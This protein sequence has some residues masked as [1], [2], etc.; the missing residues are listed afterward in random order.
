MMDRICVYCGSN[1]GRSA[2][3]EAAARQL[4]ATLAQQGIGLVYG[5]ASVGIMGILADEML[6]QGGEVVGV[7]PRLLVDK[8][9]AHPGLTELKIVQ[10]MHQRKAQMAELADGFIG[11]AGRPRNSGG[12]V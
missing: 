10:S 8:E 12:A 5:G 1:P 6:A 9:V 4:A 7:I 3:Y 2:S 11:P